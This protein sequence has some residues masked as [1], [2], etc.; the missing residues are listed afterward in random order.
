MDLFKGFIEGWSM[1]VNEICHENN[2]EAL[3]F[4]I[5]FFTVIF[6]MGAILGLAVAAIGYLVERLGKGR[7]SHESP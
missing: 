3:G 4:S 2:L 5:G 1:A 7:K 6:A